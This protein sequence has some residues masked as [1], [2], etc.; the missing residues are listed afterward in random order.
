MYII[1]LIMVI[2]IIIIIVSIIV[3]RCSCTWAGLAGAL[4]WREVVAARLQHL[5][6]HLLRLADRLVR[7][8][9]HCFQL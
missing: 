7:Y 8:C 2:I 1:L 6:E 9:C 4:R 3:V 5:P